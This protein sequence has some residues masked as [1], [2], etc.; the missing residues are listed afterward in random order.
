MAHGGQKNRFQP[1]GLHRFFL[2]D[3]QFLGVPDAVAHVVDQ[4]EHPVPFKRG[5]PRLKIVPSVLVQRIFDLFNLTVLQALPYIAN[6]EIAHLRRIDRPPV[7]SDQLVH[8]MEQDR[9]PRH[10]HVGNNKTVVQDKNKFR[11]CLDDFPVPLFEAPD[12]G[13]FFAAGSDVRRIGDQFAGTTLFVRL[14]G[15]KTVFQPNR[16]PLS[17]DAAHPYLGYFGIGCQHAFESV[18]VRIDVVGMRET[19]K[20]VDIREF[21]A[22]IP[23][24]QHPEIIVVETAGSRRDI[25]F[26]QGDPV[27]RQNGNDVSVFVFDRMIVLFRRKKAVVFVHVTL[28]G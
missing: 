18:S 5:D 26:P 7:R 24:P 27:S 15:E 12:A 22:G 10:Q 19:V 14:A 8:R 23:E 20:I 9:A 17:A 3:D 13:L 1:V 25:V 6:E 2:R 11:Q 4:R 16:L 28:F 21:D